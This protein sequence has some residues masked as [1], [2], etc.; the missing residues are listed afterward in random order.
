MLDTETA[1]VNG[2]GTYTTPNGFV[3]TAIGTYL[4]SATYSGDSNNNPV[5][6]PGLSTT[7]FAGSNGQFPRVG[8]I[9]GQRGECLRHDVGG[10]RQQRRHDL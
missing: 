2:N 1:T 10:R 7:A 5:S 9:L 3:P 4:W 8:V 6:A